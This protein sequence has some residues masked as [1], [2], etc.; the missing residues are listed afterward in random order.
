MFDSMAYRGQ[1]ASQQAA[2]ESEESGRI[3]PCGVIRGTLLKER[4]SAYPCLVREKSHF[5]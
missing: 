3:F 1:P 5:R 2:W 4:D